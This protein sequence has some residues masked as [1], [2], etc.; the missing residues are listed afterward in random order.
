[1]WPYIR[2][3]GSAYTVADAHYLLPDSGYKAEVQH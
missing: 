3:P 2:L 1:M